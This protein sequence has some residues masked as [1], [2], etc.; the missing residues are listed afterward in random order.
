MIGPLLKDFGP[1]IFR[2]THH[3]LD[4]LFEESPAESEAALSTEVLVST[5]RHF[6]H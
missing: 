3:D 1:G 5:I 4:E 6:H 2:I